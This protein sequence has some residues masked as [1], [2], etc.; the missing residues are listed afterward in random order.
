MAGT[1]AANVKSGIYLEKK[2]CI[3]M[4]VN[5]YAYIYTCMCIYTFINICFVQK[6]K[7]VLFYTKCIKDLRDHGDEGEKNKERLL[8]LDPSWRNRNRI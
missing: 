8:L 6:I 1:E 3:Y 5:I 4:C 2:K 7:Y